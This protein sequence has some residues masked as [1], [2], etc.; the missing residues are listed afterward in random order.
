MIKE[1]VHLNMGDDVVGEVAVLTMTMR[2][3]AK[4]TRVDLDRPMLRGV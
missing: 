4:A 1:R 2:L 3:V